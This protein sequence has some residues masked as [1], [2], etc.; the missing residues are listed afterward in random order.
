[1]LKSVLNGYRLCGSVRDN[2]VMVDT[3]GKLVQALTIA[4]EVVFEQGRIEG[5]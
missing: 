3:E 1:V 2:W 5:S 4:A